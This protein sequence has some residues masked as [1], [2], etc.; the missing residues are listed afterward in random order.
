MAGQQEMSLQS[1]LCSVKS[2]GDPTLGRL[3]MLM[4]SKL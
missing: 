2:L 3:R 1:R 4:E